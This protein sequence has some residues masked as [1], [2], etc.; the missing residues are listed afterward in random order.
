MLFD[1]IRYPITDIYNDDE[2]DALPFDL[3]AYWI[4]DVKANRV[5]RFPAD[6]KRSTIVRIVQQT[7]MLELLRGNRERDTGDLIKAQM[8]YRLKQMIA[9][10]EA[11]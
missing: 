5:H 7:R 4:D 1:V 8:T 3:W 10:Y 6:G 11:N 2:L 9:E